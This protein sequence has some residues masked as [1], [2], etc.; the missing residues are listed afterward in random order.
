MRHNFTHQVDNFLAG[1]MSQNARAAIEPEVVLVD[2]VQ[3]RMFA[4]TF[5][6]FKKK[7]RASGAAAMSHCVPWIYD[8]CWANNYRLVSIMSA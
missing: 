6:I 3:N 2:V 4:N 8:R 5:M 7:L 1:I